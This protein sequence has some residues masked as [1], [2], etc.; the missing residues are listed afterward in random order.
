MRHVQIGIAHSNKPGEARRG[1]LET[2]RQ[3]V[4]Q[5]LQGSHRCHVVQVMIVTLQPLHQRVDGVASVGGDVFGRPVLQEEALVDA[6]T[7]N[8]NHSI[9]EGRVDDATQGKDDE[10]NV[11][12]G[13]R[14]SHLHQSHSVGAKY[15][16]LDSDVEGSHGNHRNFV[17]AAGKGKKS[18][19]SPKCAVHGGGVESTRPNN[20][21]AN[22]EG[23]AQ[24]LEAED[25]QAK[26]SISIP[27][28]NG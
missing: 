20:G 25:D 21:V 22:A 10:R 7:K 9:H 18:K 15:T 8:R 3:R 24:C 4:V 19:G 17:R 6:S 14:H 2:C 28:C 12:V 26:V 1:R 23:C 11:L 13:T 16:H 5:N 27:R